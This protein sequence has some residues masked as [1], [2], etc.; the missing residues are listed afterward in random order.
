MEENNEELVAKLERANADL[1]AEITERRLADEALRENDIRFKKLS[2]HVPGM[3]YQF[4]MRL[5]G[6]FCVPFTTESIEDIFGCSPQD[7]REDFSP[8]A[9]VIL[10]ED[11]DK[12]V[13]SIRY[14]AEHLTSWQCEYRVQIPG[15]PARWMLGQSTPEKLADGSII[16][17]GFNTDITE[18]KKDEE[19]LKAVYKRLDATL[20]ALPDL[21]FEVDA[22]GV[23]YDYRA[24]NQA[25]LYVPTEAFLGKSVQ[26]I[27]PQE[28]AKAMKQALNEA[29]EK[30][31]H[32]GMTYSL[33]M[34]HGLSFYELSIAPV[35]NNGAPDGRFIVL[36]RDITE[37]KRME[38]EKE[39]L[40]SDLRNA[41]AQIKT[42]QGIL[43][44]C[45]FCK[46]IRDDKDYWHR[47]EI[48]ISDHSEAQFSHGIC[49]ECAKERGYD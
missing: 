27:F 34:P 40:I 13:D 46:K 43:P 26:E 18:R 29:A 24:S 32:T 39:I 41:L 10:P 14:S 37:R 6:T 38:K 45:M 42:L 19:K 20:N 17:H 25:E 22:E 9:R 7:V 49:P 16:W 8:I 11:L 47:V 48:Y 23:I 28:T 36:A 4:M 15:R 30:G 31:K 35:V 5:D 33:Q 12:V 3:I 1:Q 2:S 44:I 21:M